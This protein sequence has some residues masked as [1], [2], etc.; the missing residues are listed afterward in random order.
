MQITKLELYTN[1][2][3]DRIREMDKLF[4]LLTPV[5][6]EIHSVNYSERFWR[7]LLQGYVS[8]VLSR[9]SEYKIK[10]V[11]FDIILPTGAK[12]IGFKR[13]FYT[14]LRYALKVVQTRNNINKINLILSRDMNICVSNLFG[15]STPAGVNE[16]IPEYYFLPFIFKTSIGKRSKLKDISQRHNDLFLQNIILS[17]PQIFVEYFDFVMNKVVLNDAK[18]K[19]FHSTII[20]STFTRYIVAKYVENGSLLY[21]YQHGGNYGEDKYHAAY[22]YESSIS[23]KYHTWGWTI[24][25]ADIP[26]Y[27]FRVESFIEKYDTISISKKYD[28]LLVFGRFLS[29]NSDKYIEKGLK[30]ACNINRD[31]YVNILARPRKESKNSN[32]INNLMFL[33]K[34]NITFDQ[35]HRHEAPLIIKQ[36]KIVILL[37]YPSTFAFE[38]MSV[39]HPILCIVE[40]H[41]LT[42]IAEPHYINMYDLQIFHKNIESIINF[43]NNVEINIWWNAIVLDERYLNFKNTFMQRNK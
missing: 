13:K 14:Y 11:G 25:A 2:P 41:E 32:D 4:L 27:A 20:S 30:F 7:I 21:G 10:I 38:C 18:D 12:H 39:N 9:Y 22:H 34:Y 6:N 40:N 3:K 37:N 31:K 33:K 8:T 16:V 23:D 28:C 43:L 19:I 42:S 1:T 17:I 24:S 15:T 5:M 26:Y 29:W 36:S 35:G